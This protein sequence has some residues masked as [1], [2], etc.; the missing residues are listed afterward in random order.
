MFPLTVD[1]AIRII[2]TRMRMAEPTRL[3]APMKR[4][5]VFREAHTQKFETFGRETILVTK[6]FLTEPG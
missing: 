4:V 2:E 5:P 1:P 3:R 6:I